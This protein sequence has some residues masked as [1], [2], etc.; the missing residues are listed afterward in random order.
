MHTHKPGGGL[1]EKVW[2]SEVLDSE[3]QSVWGPAAFQLSSEV[4]P[5]VDPR[6]TASHAIGKFEAKVVNF[7]NTQNLTHL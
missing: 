4:T 7:N 6:L 1:L 5:G 2:I 3:A